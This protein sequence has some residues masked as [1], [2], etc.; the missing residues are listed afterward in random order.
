M[1][2]LLL[3]IKLPHTGLRRDGLLYRTGTAPIRAPHVG[4]ARYVR[5]PVLEG[6]SQ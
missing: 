6:V 4:F 5:T 3:F 1:R 2:Y